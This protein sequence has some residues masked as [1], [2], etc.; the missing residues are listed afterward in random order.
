[1]W[2]LNCDLCSLAGLKQVISEPV[3]QEGN[4]RDIKGLRADWS[5]RGFWDSQK[6]ALFDTCIFNADANYFKH[7]LFKLCLR[8]KRKSRKPNIQK[9][10]QK[11][12]H[13]SRQ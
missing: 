7:N 6:I 5:V 8:E 9:Q 4:D 3:I 1:M 12:E 10:P 13:R 11:E 2:D